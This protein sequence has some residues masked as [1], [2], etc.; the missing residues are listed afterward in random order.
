MS[1]VSLKFKRA[2]Y[3]HATYIWHMAFC[4]EQH[5]TAGPV[6]CL[7]LLSCCFALCGMQ[8]WTWGVSIPHC[9]VELNRQW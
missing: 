7:L 4:G 5:Q 2:K 6:S 9:T 3:K 8:M 1:V